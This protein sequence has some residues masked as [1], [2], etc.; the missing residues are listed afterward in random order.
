VREF[1]EVLSLIVTNIQPTTA[2]PPPKTPQILP[3]TPSLWITDHVSH[4]DC[5]PGS[6]PSS[7]AIYPSARHQASAPAGLASLAILPESV[8]THSSKTRPPRRISHHLIPSVTRKNGEWL[9]TWHYISQAAGTM[10]MQ[11]ITGAIRVRSPPLNPSTTYA[12]PPDL[13]LQSNHTRA[14]RN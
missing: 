2:P 5:N 8:L 14:H 12:F 1:A 3:P 10:L 9:G 4:S 13:A 11:N 6:R 7:R